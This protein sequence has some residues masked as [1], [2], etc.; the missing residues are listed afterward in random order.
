MA[1]SRGFRSTARSSAFGPEPPTSPTA[2]RPAHGVLEGLPGGE[3]FGP[4][5]PEP[6]SAPAARSPRRAS[7]RRAHA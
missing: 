2:A 7:S 1:C 3:L 4:R 6:P 5:R